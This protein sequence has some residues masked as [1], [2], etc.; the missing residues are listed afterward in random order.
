[1]F[2]KFLE[3]DLLKKYYPINHKNTEDFKDFSLPCTFL[4]PI[5]PR[6]VLVAE[7]YRGVKNL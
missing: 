6:D 3:R 1:M 4:Q 2:S 7:K 5:L